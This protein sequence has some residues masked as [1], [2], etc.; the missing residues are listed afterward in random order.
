MARS[1]RNWHEGGFYHVVNRGVNHTKIFLDTADFQHFM[2][3]LGVALKKFDFKLHSF[4]LMD[5]HYHMIIETG[6]DPLWA[7]M[8]FIDQSHAMYF[9]HRYHRDGPLFRGRYTSR[10]IADDNYFLQASRYISLNPFKAGMINA[11]ADYEWSSYRTLIGLSH[12]PLIERELTLSF[13]DGNREEGYREFVEQEAFDQ[14]FETMISSDIGESLYDM[15][16]K[17]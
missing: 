10:Y 17:A 13:Y 7:I 3:K 6:T 14:T 9:N 5:N 16:P 11:P 15:P 12:S 8:K 4:C 2:Y 1:L